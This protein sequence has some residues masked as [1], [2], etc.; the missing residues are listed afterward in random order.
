M[1]GDPVLTESFQKDEDVHK[2]T[3][4]DIFGVPVS[5]VDDRMRGIAKAI[6]FGLMYGKSVFGLSQELNISR[7][8]AKEMIERYF[9]R[10][11]AVKD[12]LDRQIAD[13]KECGYV[14]SVM[15]RKRKLA[16]IT[17]KNAAIRA[18]AERMAMNTPIQATAAD[19]MKLAMIKLDQ[20]LE[21]GKFQ[22]KLIIQVHD[23]V[24]LD[25]PRDEVPEIRKLVC[26]VMENAMTLSVPLR[27]NTAVGENW[28]E[29]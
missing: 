13:A 5:R 19:M 28:M 14:T 4:S 6:N 1:S 11:R 20:E 9:E 18:N 12:F 25:C 3:A 22:S 15:G 7:K 23:E 24:V 29:L 10:Y 26:K 17:S 27:V 2:R 21:K 8:D 16:D